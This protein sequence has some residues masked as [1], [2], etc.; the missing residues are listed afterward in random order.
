MSLILKA[1]PSKRYKRKISFA[2]IPAFAATLINS[3]TARR[4]DATDGLASASYQEAY[5]T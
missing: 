3:K 1:L 2:K 5:L 4:F